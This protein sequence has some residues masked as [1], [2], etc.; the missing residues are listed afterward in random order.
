MAKKIGNL[1][2]K[3]LERGGFCGVI[4]A[5]AEGGAREKLGFLPSNLSYVMSIQP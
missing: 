2:G 1:E 3:G 5:V 4:M